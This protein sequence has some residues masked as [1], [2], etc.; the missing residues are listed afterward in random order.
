MEWNSEYSVDVPTLDKQHEE[1]MRFFNEALKNCSGDKAERR[2]YFDHGID[3]FINFLEN[4]FRTEEEFLSGKNYDLYDEHKLEHTKTLEKIHLI[5]DAIQNDTC[6]INL[7]VLA[8]TLKDWFMRH[9]VE[10][11]LAARE[12]FQDGSAQVA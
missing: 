4:H 5:K 7:L 3:G 11:D 8:V 10:Y 12:Y 9:F 6:V 1:L 2:K